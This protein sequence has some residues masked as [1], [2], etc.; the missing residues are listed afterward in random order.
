MKV[1]VIAHRC[2]LIGMD[3]PSETSVGHIISTMVA[4]TGV[5]LDVQSKH[6]LVLEFKKKLK[7]KFYKTSGELSLIEYPMNPCDLP[8]PRYDQAYAGSPPTSQSFGFSDSDKFLRSTASKLKSEPASAPMQILNTPTPDIGTQIVQGLLRGI[9]H[10]SQG[11]P[12]TGSNQPPLLQL[13]RPHSA[14]VPAVHASEPNVNHMAILDYPQR[15]AI[16]QPTNN[17]ISTPV[18]AVTPAVSPAAS[19]AASL[20][21]PTSGSQPLG[22]EAPRAP[23]AVEYS[24]AVLDAYDA[25]AS[26]KKRPAAAVEPGKGKAKAA[27]KQKVKAKSGVAKVDA[28]KRPAI[29]GKN[30]G[31]THYLDGKIHRSE[32]RQCWRVFVHKSDRCDKAFPHSVGVR[33]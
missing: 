32:T 25:R 23:N 2:F 17:E 6:Q 29:L 22:L 19:P 11:F 20:A 24:Q 8:E 14:A 33:F 30:G 7:S 3:I 13:L 1:E 28:A 12:A 26:A 31:T 5:N 9:M 4:I 10:I 18:K 16:I 27:P 21:G 15:P